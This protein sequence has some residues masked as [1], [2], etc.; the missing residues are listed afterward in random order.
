M[1]KI[2]GKAKRGKKSNFPRKLKMGNKIETD[3]YE[4]A[5]LFNKYFAGIGPS[6]ARNIPDPSIPL[7][8]QSLSINELKDTF[9][10]LK[11]NKSSGADEINFNVIKHCFGE[12]CGPLKYL[13]DSSLQRVVFSDLLKMT[14]ISPVFKT[15]DTADISNFCQFQFFLVSQKSLNA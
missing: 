12:F 1:K 15:S 7:P 8:S 4:I 6:F 14:I 2:I 5:N 9:F 13:F 10:S 11:A 3:E